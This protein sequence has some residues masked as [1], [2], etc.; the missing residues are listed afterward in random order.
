MFTEMNSEQ[1]RSQTPVSTEEDGER[2]QA[3]KVLAFS[4][5]LPP[6]AAATSDARI[7]E[8]AV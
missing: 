3:Q 2:C 8:P 5:A 4:S 7:V 6:S 1:H